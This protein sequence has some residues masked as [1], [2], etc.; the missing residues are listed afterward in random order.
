LRPKIQC[1]HFWFTIGLVFVS[2]M[3]ARC[4]SV[5]VALR[6][7]TGRS[8]FH[9]GEVILVDL[10]FV[11]S[12]PDSY[13]RNSGV[14]LPE[15]Y[16]MPDTFFAEPREGWSD[17]LG[18][19]RKALFEAEHSGRIPITGFGISSIHILGS[20]PYTFSLVLNDYVRFSKPGHYFLQVQDS[21]VTSVTTQPGAMPEHLTLTSN[22]LQLV[23]LPAD[24]EWEQSQ[25]KES[26]DSLAQLREA[27]DA[28]ARSYRSSL[29]DG[30]VNLRAMGIPAA[31]TTMVNS[32][33][34][35]G[36]FSI[37]SFQAGILEYPD[38]KFI[39]EQLRKQLNDPDFPVTSMFF[40]MMAM[41]S[42]LAQGHPDQLFGTE[43]E[44]IDRRLEQQLLSVV[45]V[46]RNQA[47][48]ETISTLVKTCFAPYGGDKGAFVRVPGE[49]SGLNSRVLKC[50]TANSAQL[51]PG[52]QKILSNYR[53]AHGLEN[54]VP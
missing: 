36:L 23:I 35:E 38:P 47:K 4:Q 16:P 7:E 18:E 30:C 29:S 53:K 2:F 13:E 46:K 28:H 5:S 42:I 10:V 22:R 26:L 12:A 20:E 52:V 14:A 45:S 27:I 48:A 8:E 43:R 11:A 34:S 32:L 44:T 31:G 3:V 39:L 51:A 49:P 24:A 33:R 37:C 19:Y 15:R 1:K 50:A 21:G 54:A 9:M 6:T 41:I 40:N 25:L 17:P